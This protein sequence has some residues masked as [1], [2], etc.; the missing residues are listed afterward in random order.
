MVNNTLQKGLLY[1]LQQLV[2][3]HRSA[4]KQERSF[5]RAVGQVLGEVFNF[6]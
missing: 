5:W 4:F 1:E 6:G 3:A 2:Q